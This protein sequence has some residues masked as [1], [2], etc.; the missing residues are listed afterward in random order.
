MKNTNG[1]FLLAIT[2]CVFVLSP[3][4]KPSSTNELEQA[5]DTVVE[6]QPIGPIKLAVAGDEALTQ[7]IER[8]WRTTQ[9]NDLTVT[10]LDGSEFSVDSIP[11]D[12]DVVIYPT[13]Y[14]ANLATGEFVQAI[15]DKSWDDPDFNSREFLEAERGEKTKWAGKVVA[16]SLGEPRPVLMFR[17][18]VFEQHQLKVPTTWSEFD[19]LAKQIRQ[20]RETA[21]NDDQ[22]QLAVLQLGDV[23]STSQAGLAVSIEK[24]LMI[25]AANYLVAKGQFSTFFDS[26]TMEPMVNTPPF[27]RALQELVD[28]ASFTEFAT[29]RTATEKILNGECCLAITWPSAAWGLD[30]SK[31]EST[32]ADSIEIAPLPGSDVNYNFTKE[33]WER[34]TD[35]SP[36]V[37]DGISGYLVSCSNNARR[38]GDAERFV[39]WLTSKQTL[40]QLNSVSPFVSMSRAS[41]L[42]Q[43]QRWATSSFSQE[44]LN[45]F[46]DAIASYNGSGLRCSWLPVNQ[47]ERYEQSMHEAVQAAIAGDVSSDAAL[48]SLAN[49]WNA[50]TDEL[51]RESQRLSYRKAIGLINQW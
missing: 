11:S 8:L 17:R 49:E 46:A 47:A 33:I 37:V 40:T 12:I 48:S 3:G 25:R 14:K 38:R 39:T 26:R 30:E 32:I 42:G 36:V 4:C 35:S 19:E 7:D 23:S 31:F 28:S 24:M 50:I 20:L 51:D 16:A 18:D 41:H 5:D 45:S 29:P 9:S 6:Q 43:P 13:L 34:K 22:T 27:Q 10:Q 21:S 1:P 2:I 44:S 15:S